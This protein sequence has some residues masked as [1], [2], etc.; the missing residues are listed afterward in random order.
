MV[1]HFQNLA[2]KPRP[3]FGIGQIY[4]QRLFHRQAVGN[5]E[6]RD[7]RQEQHA[8][9]EGDAPLE[10]AQT[11]LS[12]VELTELVAGFRLDPPDRTTVFEPGFVL[13]RGHS[14]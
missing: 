2:D 9:L 11:L 5:A 12:L 6:K 10:Y 14:F 1:Q 3:H 8:R 4:F 13:V 7:R